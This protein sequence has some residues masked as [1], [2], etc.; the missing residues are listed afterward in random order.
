ML[1]NLSRERILLQGL[2]FLLIHQTVIL[3]LED[4]SLDTELIKEKRFEGV[5]H[6]ACARPIEAK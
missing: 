5:A 4:F 6:R 3:L 1:R 2:A